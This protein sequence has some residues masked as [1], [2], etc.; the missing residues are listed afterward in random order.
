MVYILKTLP[1]GP[2][3]NLSFLRYVIKYDWGGGNPSGPSAEHYYETKD[4]ML[5]PR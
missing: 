4:E 5:K 1:T 3:L 2:K